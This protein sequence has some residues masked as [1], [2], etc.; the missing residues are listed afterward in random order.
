LAGKS[1]PGSKEERLHR[2]GKILPRK[3]ERGKKGDFLD[4]ERGG[5]TT[6]HCQLGDF[7][8]KKRGKSGCR[9]TGIGR[10]MSDP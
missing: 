5:G 9:S 2:I 8:K 10:P 4:G 1:L 7:L 6:G 3:G